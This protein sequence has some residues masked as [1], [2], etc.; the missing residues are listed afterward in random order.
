MSDCFLTPWTVARHVTL[1]MGFPRQKFL[2]GLPFPSPGDL[3]NPGI[4]HLSPAW[5]G[6][7]LLLS[8]RG[9]PGNLYPFAIHYHVCAKL[10]QLCP[11]LCDPMDYSP[12]DSSVHGILQGRIFPTQGLNPHH[13]HLL[14][15][16]V[17]VSPLAPPGKPPYTTISVP[18]ERGYPR[19]CKSSSTS[20]SRCGLK[21]WL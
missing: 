5:A 6:K 20:S 12:P 15:W 17:G 4:E 9:S 11:A 14:H 18:L 21:S 7:F 16:Q 3:L 1:F 2:N 13:L 8:H 19:E 10:L